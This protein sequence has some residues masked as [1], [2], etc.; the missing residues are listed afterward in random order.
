MIYLMLFC[1]NI[2][3]LECKHKCMQAGRVMNGTEGG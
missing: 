1:D 3:N 2:S